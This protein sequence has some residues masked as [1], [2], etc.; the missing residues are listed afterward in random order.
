M[1]T[2]EVNEEKEDELWEGELFR[3]QGDDSTLE[4]LDLQADVARSDEDI[5]SEEETLSTATLEASE[6]APSILSDTEDCNVP[7]ADTGRNPESRRFATYP[8]SFFSSSLL[9]IYNGFALPPIIDDFAS[10]SAVQDTAHGTFT[11]DREALWSRITTAQANM[12]LHNTSSVSSA[13]Y[14]VPPPPLSSPPPLP[15]ASTPPPL[16][17]SP[18][19]LRPSVTSRVYSCAPTEVGSD[20]DSVDMDISDSE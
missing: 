12:T 7:S 3:I 17:S 8:D 10:R 15:P 18:P 5:S 11:A 13:E 1:I 19:S 2:E 4:N 14:D 16:P 9:P 20:D 6:A